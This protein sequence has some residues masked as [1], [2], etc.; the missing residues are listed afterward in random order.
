MTLPD[1]H[2][3][4]EKNGNGRP[5]NA[6]ILICAGKMGE[7]P[8]S[9]FPGFVIYRAEDNS[10]AGLAV[11][12]DGPIRCGENQGNDCKVFLTLYND[13]GGSVPDS[14]FEST[15]QVVSDCAGGIF[16]LYTIAMDCRDFPAGRSHGIPVH[17]SDIGSDTLFLQVMGNDI[18]Y[19]VNDLPLNQRN[20]LIY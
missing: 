20:N 16:Y 11:K 3:A 7:K 1:S 14:Q 4:E 12:D 17:N 5:G 13:S 8:L 15:D 6:A 19:C 2:P 18:P 9:G 10:F